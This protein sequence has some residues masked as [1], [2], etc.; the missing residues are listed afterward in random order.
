MLVGGSADLTPSNNTAI[1]GRADFEAASLEGLY[2]R[3]GIR[4]HAMGSI[5]NGIALSRLWIPYGGTFLIFYDY[6]RPPV[7]LA[8]LMHIQTIY[9]YTHDSIFLGE[10]GPHP[11]AHRATRRPALRP[12][13]DADPPGGRHRD[14]RSLARRGRAPARPRRSRPDA[15]E[16]PHPGRDG[17]REPAKG[18]PKAPTSFPIPAQ[19]DPEIIL[20]ATGSEVWLVVEASKQ[21]TEKGRRVR[22]VSMPS[23]ALFDA[24][25]QEYRDSVLPPKDPQAPRHR[26]AS[27]LGWHKYVGLDGDVHGIERFGAS[28]PYKD[29]QKAF[30]FLPEDVVKRAGG[31]CWGG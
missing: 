28:G 21:L 14:G 24:Q 30:E 6:M 1:K 5:M 3:F 26:S 11:P 4:E 2:F 17:R 23:W 13:P 16:P 10:D 8:S 27:P 7:R 19:G 20:L 12:R 29:L 15:A 25:P 9:V 22:V 31:G 18:C